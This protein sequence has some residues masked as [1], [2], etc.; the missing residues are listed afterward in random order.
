MKIVKTNLKFKDLG[1]KPFAIETPP[2]HIKLNCVALMVAKRGMGK[3]FFTS[4][5]LDWLKFDRIIIGAPVPLV[6]IILFLFN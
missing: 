3:T 5:L 6:I 2:E 1:T 4:N